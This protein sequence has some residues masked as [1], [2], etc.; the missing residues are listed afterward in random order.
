MRSRAELEW[1]RR[2]DAGLPAF[3]C[4]QCK[5]P[6]AHWGP[7]GLDEN[8]DVVRGRFTCAPDELAPEMSA[9]D[10]SGGVS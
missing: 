2:K 4:P 7:D 6:E 10:F 5:S 8:G 1:Q 9:L 3:L